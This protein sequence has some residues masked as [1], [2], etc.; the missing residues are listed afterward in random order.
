MLTPIGRGAAVVVCMAAAT[1]AGC[2]SS[3][4]S[5]SKA[6]VP[7]TTTTSS[8]AHAGSAATSGA[9]ASTSGWCAS[10]GS[11]VRQLESQLTAQLAQAG[12]TNDRSATAA[13]LD[14]VATSVTA[15]A[16]TAPSEIKGDLTTQQNA[17]HQA[18]AA[19]RGGQSPSA[20]FGSK[21]FTDAVAHLQAWSKANCRALANG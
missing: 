3:S 21:A 17:I 5:S 7:T 19:I 10:A 18:A 11:K 16:A 1:L 13:A 20:V 15:F 8:G 9:P 6:P 4:T 14:T 2:G 12:Q